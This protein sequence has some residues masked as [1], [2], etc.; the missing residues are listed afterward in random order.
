VEGYLAVGRTLAL[1]GPSGVGKSTLVNRLLGEELLPT[2]EVRAWDQRG[3]HTSVHRQL[4]VRAAGG[5]IVDTPGM[6]EL[7][8]WESAEELGDAFHDIAA[9]ADGCRFRDCVHDQEPGCAVKAAVASGALSADR[10]DSY[11][12]L[13]HEA[14]ATDKLRD[15]RAQLEEKRQTRIAQR[16]PN[17]QQRSRHRE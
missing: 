4:V 12:T 16:A 11:L 5:L 9:L 13:R 8:L 2:G 7:Q 3:R 14:A 17:A 10:Y 1:L 6:R 15:E